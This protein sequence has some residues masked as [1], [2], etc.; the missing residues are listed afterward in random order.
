MTSLWPW[1]AVAG[2][3][4]LH[5][6]NPA[7]GWLL[8]AAWGLHTRDRRQALRALLPI[9]AGHVASV[10]LVVAAVASGLV[11]DRGVV[12]MAA[13]GLLVVAVALHLGHG[14]PNRLRAPAG[15]AGLAIGSFLA[16]T[17]HGAG[18]ALVPALLPLC[19]GQPSADAGA[20]DLL[21]P[22][23]AATAVHL[24]AMLAVTALVATAVARPLAVV[25]CRLG[26]GKRENLVM[27]GMPP[28]SRHAGVAPGK[29]SCR[30]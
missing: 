13:G 22:A 16:G 21:M 26:W 29:S 12:R 7:G 25:V 10:G 23:L 17:T 3:G 19:L 1:L 4:A 6:L 15:P 27:W 5:G 28:E 24:A 8:A 20:I 30:G 9:A 14:L 2:F 11:P 18:L